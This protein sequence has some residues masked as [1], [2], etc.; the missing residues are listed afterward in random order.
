MAGSPPAP[1][2]ILALS[3]TRAGVRNAALGLAEAIAA[4]L[5]VEAAHFALP[6]AKGLLQRRP[7]LPEAAPTI[8]VGAGRAAQGALVA[9][10]RRGAKTV[11]V[12]DPRR[13]YRRF[14]LVVAPAHDRV[15]ERVG[16]PNLV[17]TIGGPN[18]ITPVRLLAARREWRSLAELP[19]PRAGVLVGGPSGRQG[20]T[21]EVLARHTR[22]F[23]DVLLHGGS[24][25]VTTSR[26]TPGTVRDGL[27]RLAE[28]HPGRVWVWDGSGANPY[29]G[30]LA[31]A[32]L[33]L[34]TEE[35]SNMLCEACA[36]AKPVFRLPM[37]GRPG[38]FIRLYAQLAERCHVRPWDGKLEAEPYIPLQETR[39]AAKIVV[40]RL[41]LERLAL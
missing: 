21:A 9:L 15:G 30:L 8:A 5:G 3:D 12:Q 39:R 18:R 34:V 40:E 10:G 17:E 36:T 1:A 19:S 4:R 6:R 33:V 11:Y 25:L 38:K 16:V 14:D 20:F 24:L 26:R 31:H 37:A 35:S 22:A 32:E 29:L 2:S 41:G 23:A 27:E 13:A 28:R 7:P